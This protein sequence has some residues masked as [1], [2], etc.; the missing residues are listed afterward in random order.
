MAGK[1]LGCLWL[2]KSNG[3]EWEVRGLLSK[4]KERG[5]SWAAP[6]NTPARSWNPS[7]LQDPS[8]KADTGAGNEGSIYHNV[9]SLK[10]SGVFPKARPPVFLAKQVRC[11]PSLINDKRPGLKESL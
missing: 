11:K 2:W 6:I 5:S 7:S 9:Y 8:Q 3:R 10:F 1:I 4:E